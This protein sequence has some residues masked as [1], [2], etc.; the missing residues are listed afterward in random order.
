MA[1]EFYQ[2]PSDFF[3]KNAFYAFKKKSCLTSI[4]KDLL[5]MLNDADDHDT[6]IY[7]GENGNT[8]EFRAHSNMLRARSSYFKI[9]L[10]SIWIKR[11]NIIKFKKPNISVKVFEILIK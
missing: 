3:K 11:N 5:S 9:A 6:I 10:S 8:K 7:V 2:L 1:C 4:S